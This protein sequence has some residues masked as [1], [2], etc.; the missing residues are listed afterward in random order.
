MP[1]AHEVGG[2]VLSLDRTTRSRRCW[3]ADAE[4]VQRAVR[5]RA[6]RQR[7]V[8]SARRV[9]R[10]EPALRRAVDRGRLPPRTAGRA[11]R[12]SARLAARA[13]AMF[14][15][16]ARRPRPHLD[17]KIL[18][19]WNG[20][21]I[22]AFARGA[23]VLRPARTHLAAA[24]RAARV[25]ARRAVGR[26]AP[27]AA[28]PVPRRA[29]PPS[30]AMPR[31]TRAWSGACSSCSRPTATRRGSSGRCDSSAGRTSCSGTRRRRL[32]QHDRAQDPSR[33]RCG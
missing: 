9:R 11:P 27:H 15:A 26:G 19:A 7:A 10:Q 14:E 21:M 32:V 25:P 4:L 3:A 29:T 12:S 13:G 30:T 16:R 18:T 24:A 22:A 23:R 17:D 33:A 5:H 31:T 28:P 6:A 8:R 1:G 2:R 20:L